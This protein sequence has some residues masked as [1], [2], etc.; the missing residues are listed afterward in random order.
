MKN[1]ESDEGRYIDLRQ[2]AQELLKKKRAEDIK[3]M[4]EADI[5]AIV[6]EL[7]VHQIE[8]EMQNEELQRAYN[9]AEEM[10]DRYIDLFDFSPVG[11][12]TL[13]EDDGSIFEVNLSGAAMLGIERKNLI[14]RRFAQ[15]VT[16]EF[17][18]TFNDFCKKALKS[19]R[20]QTC[21]VQLMK[22]DLPSFH[23]QIEGIAIAR[24]KISR[25]EIRTS[26]IDITDR[27]RADEDREQI[28]RLESLGLLAGGIAHD[29]NNLLS[30]IL[31]NINLAKMYIDPQ[32]KAFKRIED[33]EFASMKA[34]DLTRQLLTFSRGGAPVRKIIQMGDLLKNSINFSLSGSKSR[35]EI[36]IA[37]NC[38]PV[39]V[40]EGQMSQVI[41]NL[42]INADQSMPQGGAIR[43]SCE[44]ASLEK[45]KTIFLKE[46]PYVKV[47][48]K[49]EGV[50]IPEEYLQKVFDPYF[51]TKERGK[52][53]GLATAYSIIKRH[54]GYIT[55]ESQPGKGT[56]FHIYLPASP[57][58]SIA[59]KRHE[60]LIEGKGRVL[61]MDDED[62]VIQVATE[63]LKRLGY[64]VEVSKDGSEAIEIYKKAMESGRAFDAVIMDLTI[65]GGMGGKEAIKKLK[66]IDPDV[67][68]IVSSGYS[69][70][71]ILAE[72]RDYGFAGVVSKPYKIQ[73]LSEELHGVVNP[74]F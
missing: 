67:R 38:W 23:A 69:N 55:V 54:E 47:T 32:H 60:S 30:G 45:D 22:G 13:N 4:S 71:P 36:K 72:Y 5:R 35:C 48:V 3:F 28:H 57:D 63:M 15:F 7:Q 31:G 18:E 39:N 68:A 33:A 41:N 66:E 62:I 8:I 64:E 21:E 19:D 24:E 74:Q 59:A 51:T 61:I 2:C 1:D 42:L 10:R 27:K 43:V 73:K 14:G 29:F 25:K 58:A 16:P 46:C 44:N 26:L 40:D 11:Y 56:A 6:H 37:D 53:L 34:T 49:D 50:G 20:K 52:G 12:F 17:R 9:T 70:D 65:P